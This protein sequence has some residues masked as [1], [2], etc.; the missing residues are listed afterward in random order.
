MTPAFALSLL[1]LLVAQPAFSADDQV[2][3][4]G[5]QVLP[6]ADTDIEAPALVSRAAAQSMV[7]NGAQLEEVSENEAIARAASHGIMLEPNAKGSPNYG[8]PWAIIKAGMGIPS[9]I[10]LLAEIYINDNWT[11]EPGVNV[12][13]SYGAVMLGTRWHPDALC[14]NCKGTVSFTLSPGA[15]VGHAS[16]GEGRNAGTIIT[17]S[18]EAEFRYRP[19]KHFILAAGLRTSDGTYIDDP[20]YKTEYTPQPGHQNPDRPPNPIDNPGDFTKVA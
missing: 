3:G 16:A 19:S 8:R 9:G 17:G 15:E 7:E 6:V 2:F 11:I 10:N 1:A 13:V 5:A 14:W 4:S 12:T 20:G 18:D